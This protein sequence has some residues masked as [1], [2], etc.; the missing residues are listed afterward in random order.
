MTARRG[1]KRC[2]LCAHPEIGRMELLLAGGASITSVSQKFK[3]SY[4]MLRRHW[5][6]HVSDAK[7]SNLILG[8]VQRTALA[9]RVCEESESVL[10]HYRVIRSGLYQTFAAAVESGDKNG[11]ALLAGRLIECCNAVARVTG[12]LANSPLIGAQTNNIFIS[13]MFAELQ[14]TLIRT[15]AQFPDARAAV[16]AA[17]RELEGRAD[18]AAPRLIE[19]E[20]Q[21]GRAAAA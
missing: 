5:R 10:D 21:D 12:Q 6:G 16:I 14:A 19:H 1:P 2:A 9:A 3:V 13:P 4:H 17:F 15:L 8:P 18:A 11:T 20:A 7:K